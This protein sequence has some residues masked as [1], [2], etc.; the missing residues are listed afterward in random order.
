[1]ATFYTYFLVAIVLLAGCSR[2]RWLREFEL[3]ERSFD[4]EAM[5]WVTGKSG[6][7]I[8]GEA[9]GLNFRYRPPI[10]PSF[11]ARIAIPEDSRH[12]VVEQ[13]K[14]LKDEE[15]NI[16]GGLGEKVDWWLP[17]TEAIIIDREQL[18]NNHYLRAAVT[19]EDDQTILYVWHS[20]F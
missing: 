6:L 11:V 15:V 5:Q 2:S 20:V 13:I 14:T 7:D 19:I 3:D 1:M 12:D 8:P 16:S 10:D 4:S 18:R 9:R 17:P